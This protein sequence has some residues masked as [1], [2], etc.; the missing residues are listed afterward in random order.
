MHVRENIVFINPCIRSR[1]RTEKD[2][3]LTSLTL[4]EKSTL[5]DLH[6][7]LYN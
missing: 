4:R 5:N 1:R 2:C 7:N 3:A 6:I